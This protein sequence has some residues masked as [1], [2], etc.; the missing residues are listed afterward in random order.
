[1]PKLTFG[2]ELFLNG[3]KFI[4]YQNQTYINISRKYPQKWK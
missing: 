1:M 2:R 4:I 3:T